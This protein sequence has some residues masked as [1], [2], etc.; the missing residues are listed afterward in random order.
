MI[1][2]EQGGISQSVGWQG[3]GG[4]AFY[5]LGEAV[6]DED[7]AINPGVAF[8]PLAAHIWFAETG[9]PMTVPGNGP[10]LGHHDGNGLA[11][12][13]GDADGQDFAQPIRFQVEDRRVFRAADI[14]EKPKQARAKF[15]LAHGLN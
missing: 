12:K 8:A 14:V 5:R 15:L 6:F 9:T 11:A 10:F 1:E 13:A 7:G 3:G 4:F 2:G